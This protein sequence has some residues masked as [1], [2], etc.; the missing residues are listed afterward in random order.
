V[1]TPREERRVTRR[2]PD[3]LHTERMIGERLKRQHADEI[4]A[5]MLDPR[6]GRTLWPTP[7]PL[8]KVKVIVQLE[9]N[10]VHWEERG[11]GI[12]LLRDRTTGE[13]VGRGGLATSPVTGTAEVAVDWAIVPERWNQGLAT[14]LAHAAIEVAFDRL[15][16]EQL[17]SLTLPHNRAS[18]RVM[19]KAGF[20]Y[21]RE[22]EHVGRPHVL[23]RRSRPVQT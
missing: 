7:N 9:S 2:A 10:I 18:R 17:I 15:A 5:L 14:E 11:F 20:H 1:T 16:L 4:L 3:E 8:P 12:W 13:M 19:E 6:V 21:D 22:I 23:Y